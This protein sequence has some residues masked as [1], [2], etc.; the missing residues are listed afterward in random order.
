M[1][2]GTV[3]RELPTTQGGAA[4]L[5]TSRRLLLVGGIV[6]VMFVGWEMLTTFV[7][8]TDDAYVRSDLI[9]F[10]PQVTGQI[11]AVHVEDNQQVHK[12]DLLVSIDPVPFQLAVDARKAELAAETPRPRRTA[13]ASPR[14]KMPQPQQWPN[15]ILPT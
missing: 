5:S 1:T 14:R 9:A 10:S 2:S 8:Y 7:A 15:V 12:G 4:R 3:V 13:I 6:L 11:A